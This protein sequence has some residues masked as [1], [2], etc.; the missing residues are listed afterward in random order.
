MTT[1]DGHDVVIR[2]AYD[3]RNASPKDDAFSVQC[4]ERGNRHF[5]DKQYTLAL[6][7]Y[8]QV[9][10]LFPVLSHPSPVQA[11]SAAPAHSA[12][13]A[14]AFGNRSAVLFNLGQYTESI[15]D[16][17]NSLH[18]LRAVNGKNDECDTQFVC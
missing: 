14:R 1:T 3:Y 9:G 18:I 10:Q 6:D 13:L 17:D 4:R 12:S 15:C 2:H 11:V 5:S 7:C 8:H 16:I